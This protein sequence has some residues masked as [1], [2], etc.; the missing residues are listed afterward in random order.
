M[1]TSKKFLSGVLASSLLLGIIT[2]SGINAK[3]TENSV[4]NEEITS[5]EAKGLLELQKYN[6]AA[7]D[8]VIGIQEEL[9]RNN[10][11][12]ET[13]NQEIETYGI[14]TEAAKTAAKKMLKN[15]KRIGQ[16]SWDRTVREYVN[17]LPIPDSAK[18]VLKKYL[19]Y[20]FVISTLN[21]VVDFGGTIEEGLSE[22]IQRT[23]CPEWLADIAARA[24]VFLLL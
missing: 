18:S 21:I 9:K 12:I 24:L 2:P 4:A 1:K 17:A 16:V 15:I 14:K 10:L 3:A 19:G 11:V 5:I 20:Q 13:S 6:L 8:I 22:Q 23:G 7:E